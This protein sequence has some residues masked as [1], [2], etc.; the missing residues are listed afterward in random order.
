MASETGFQP[1]SVAHLVQ[2]WEQMN[3]PLGI[4][5][6]SSIGRGERHVFH[7]PGGR[8]NDTTF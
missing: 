5:A 8:I 4:V 3:L 6:F 1:N 2:D 7:L